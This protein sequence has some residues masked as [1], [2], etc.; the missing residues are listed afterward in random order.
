MATGVAFYLQTLLYVLVITLRGAR[1]SYNEI[2]VS[3]IVPGRT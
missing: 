1:P 2:I 3:F